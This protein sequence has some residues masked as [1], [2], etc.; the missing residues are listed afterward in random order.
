MSGGRTIRVQSALV[1]AAIETRGGWTAAFTGDLAEVT[2]WPALADFGSGI[3]LVNDG[4]AHLDQSTAGFLAT[5]IG[6]AR[7]GKAVA[8]DLNTFYNDGGLAG[9]SS[10][11]QSPAS[12][13]F[14]IRGVGVLRTGPANTLAGFSQMRDSAQLVGG[15]LRDAT[16]G[17]DTVNGDFID[18]INTTP[19][20]T[21]SIVIP[22]L[23]A[24]LQNRSVVW[25]IILDATTNEY[26]LYVN[27][28]DFTPLIV[29]QLAGETITSPATGEQPAISILNTTGDTAP[30]SNSKVVAAAF[31]ATTS[32]LVTL[33]QHR[34]DADSLGL[35]EDGF[36]IDQLGEWTWAWQFRDAEN[37]GTDSNPLIVIPAFEDAGDTDANLAV[38]GDIDLN[39]DTEEL[40]R[41]GLGLGRTG[42]AIEPGEDTTT[43]RTS[44]GLPVVDDDFHIRV[45]FRVNSAPAVDQDIIFVEDPD[46]GTLQISVTVGGA[47]PDDLI[48]RA[49]TG[50]IRTFTNAV[51]LDRWNVLDFQVDRN[52]GGGGEALMIARLNGTDL[53]ATAHTSTI[54]DIPVGATVALFGDRA[55]TNGAAEDTRM[56]FAGIAI[57]R[58]V[59]EGRSQVDAASLG[60]VF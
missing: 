47:N 42:H 12:A 10:M 57:G 27:G 39:L 8:G 46:D 9:P 43:I 45:I 60:L 15:S 20:P 5:G 24:L 2:T 58:L 35:R 17:T 13:I 21:T 4:G 51:P 22:G 44:A 1:A 28:I 18:T 49:T 25:D 52:G 19:G 38:V 59:T 16:A 50:Y 33:D 7:V 14:H 40:R 31:G 54:P 37:Q 32:R 55:L 6:S 36:A 26:V 48:L 34:A 56:A 29:S 11:P 3:S 23:G 30:A 53:S 41:E